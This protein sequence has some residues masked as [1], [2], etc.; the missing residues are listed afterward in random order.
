M[1]HSL[2]RDVCQACPDNTLQKVRDAGICIHVYDLCKPVM[3]KER[4][5]QRLTFSA[6]TTNLV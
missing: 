2:S 6:G 1:K 5:I 3:E 4:A